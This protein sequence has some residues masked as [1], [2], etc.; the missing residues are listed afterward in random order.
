MASMQDAIA[1]W[2]RM[3]GYQVS[4]IPG[5]DHAGIGTQS[6][7]EK[8]LM[9]Q[10]K[11]SYI[12][13]LLECRCGTIC[14]SAQG[15]A[16]NTCA[17]IFPFIDEIWK[18]R[19]HYGDR[20]IQQMASHQLVR[21]AS[22]SIIILSTLTFISSIKQRRLGISADW[23]RLFFTLDEPRSEA[24][25]SA[26]VRLFDDGLI[27]RDTRLV[28]WCC[29]LETVISDIEVWEQLTIMKYKAKHSSIFQVAQKGGYLH[30][31]Q[32]EFGV[33]HKFAYPVID[34]T[35]GGITELVVA[36]TRIETMLGDCAS[37]WDTFSLD[38]SDDS[39]GNIMFML[40]VR[41]HV[42]PN[43]QSLHSKEVI[44]PI[45]DKHIPIVCDAKLVDM[46]FGTGAV[47]V[48][49]TLDP[50]IFEFEI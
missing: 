17:T 30:D 44:H 45:L 24:V 42:L 46:E 16:F 32:V 13:V 48:T 4:W 37:L 27:Y 7:V 43:S 11:V 18:W 2:R 41:C 29:A 34:P 10:E 25:R 39:S 21:F 12:P 14:E 22:C 31:F 50:L 26:F 38:E 36:T 1:R 3:S 8:Q 9:K 20:I 40:N 33:L 28:N 47:K 35:P 5:T 15:S 23:N 49:V 19:V 6:V